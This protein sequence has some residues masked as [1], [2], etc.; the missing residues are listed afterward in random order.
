[1]KV[2]RVAVTE[3]QLDDVM[4]QLPEEFNILFR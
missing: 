3:G 1:M 2:L 4:A